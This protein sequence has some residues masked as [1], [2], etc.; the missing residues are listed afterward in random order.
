MS[1]KK[2]E[3][4]EKLIALQTIDSILF[5][6]FHSIASIPDE[7]TSAEA[8]KTKEQSE[9]KQLK[10][11]VTGVKL[12]RRKKETDL[13]ELEEKIRDLQSKQTVIKTNKEYLAF[14]DEISALKNKASSLEDTILSLLDNEA[15]LEEKEMQTA[16]NLEVLTQ[17]FEIKKKELLEKEENL[18]NQQRE[19]EKERASFATTVETI[20][21]NLY[22]T[23]K[24]Q[25]KDGIAICQLEN[26]IC[27]G[28]SVFAP[29]YLEE[30]VLKKDEIVQCENCRRILY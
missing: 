23:I 30:K 27:T 2:K 3:E 16:T 19:K 17:S 8:T 20:A 11:E 15:N 1:M 14:Q 4:I 7:I 25:K 28:C 10:E 5:E 22:N 24:E 21:L 6:L 12:E 9:L 26:Q 29:S 13:Q 18:R